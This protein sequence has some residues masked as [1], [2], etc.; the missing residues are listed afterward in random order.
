V[1]E[2][3]RVDAVLDALEQV[4]AAPGVV[5]ILGEDDLLEVAEEL[6]QVL[7]AGATPDLL[8]LLWNLRHHASILPVIERMYGTLTGRSAAL[9]ES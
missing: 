4:E 9:D 6:S 2:L 5:R 3:D 1:V 8:D 7:V